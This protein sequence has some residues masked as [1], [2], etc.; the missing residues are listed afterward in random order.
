[1]QR[2]VEGKE[3]LERERKWSKEMNYEPTSRKKLNFVTCASRFG[4]PTMCV[5]RV[6]LALCTVRTEYKFYKL[7]I[8]D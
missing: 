6:A 3:V 2:Y 7:F 1:M 8:T 4:F 5:V